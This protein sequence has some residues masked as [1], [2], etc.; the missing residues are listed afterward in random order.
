MVTRDEVVSAKALT[1][2]T[3]RRTGLDVRFRVLLVKLRFHHCAMQNQNL[4]NKGERKLGPRRSRQ[5]RFVQQ[6]AAQRNPLQRRALGN[7][8]PFPKT[9]VAKV[10][11]PVAE[12]KTR[13]MTRPNIIT[14]RNGDCRIVH[15]EYIADVTAAAGTPSNFIATP[16][17]INPGQAATFPWLSRIAANFESYSFTK[18][19]FGY[20]TEAASSLGGTLV[21]T[22]D[23]DAADAAPSTKQQAM[24]YRRWVRSAPW[25]SCKHVSMSEDLHKLK[26]NY[27]RLGAQPANTDIKTYDIG[28]LFVVSQGV[29]VAAATLGELYVEYDITLMTPVFEN[30]SSLV[31]VG[32]KLLGVGAMSAANPLGTGVTQLQINSYGFSVDSLSNISFPNPGN[33][34]VIVAING[35]VITGD[36]MT[37]DANSVSTLIDQQTLASQLARVS[38]WQIRVLHPSVVAY[39]AT[40][41]TITASDVWVGSAPIASLA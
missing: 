22:V 6:R 25:T 26:S 37:S 32:G 2:R 14:L 27:V 31:P 7:P 10:S 15:R 9:W 39:T 35:T 23:Y 38:V 29:G 21:L 24:S 16:Y 11:A 5:P 33:Y 20:E 30:N 4:K 28:N 8:S 13:V 36:A 34:L 41:T 17:A 1:F 19:N 40:A 12:S 18:L 3:V